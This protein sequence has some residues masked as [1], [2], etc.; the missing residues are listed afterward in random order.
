MKEDLNNRSIAKCFVQN[1]KAGHEIINRP[2]TTWPF[3]WPDS[4]A[5]MVYGY[6]VGREDM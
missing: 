6:D 2:F 4:Q 5:E 1:L 3:F